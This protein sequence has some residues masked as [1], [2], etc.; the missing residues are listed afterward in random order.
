MSNELEKRLEAIESRISRIEQYL[1]HKPQSVASSSKPDENISE[2][3]KRSLEEEPSADFKLKEKKSGNWL[4]IVAVICFILAAGFM[5]KLSIESG[6]LTPARQLGIA[7][8]FGLGLIVAGFSLLKS[9]LKYASLLPASGVIVLYLTAFGAHR[10]YSI[11]SFEAAIAITAIVSA[12]CVWL[13][14]Q[15]KSDIYAIISAS[16]AFLS[17]IVLGLNSSAEFSLYYFLLCSVT[18]ASISIWVRSRV[19]TL[20]SA[21]LAIFMTAAV[22]INLNQDIL[23]AIIL[24]IHFAIFTVATYV[25]TTEHKEPLTY[26]ESWSFLP[27]LLVFYCAEYSFLGRIHPELAP[28]ISIV[29]AGLMVGLYL[30]AKKYFPD[31]LGSQTLVIAFTTIVFF[32]SVYIELLPK[33]LKAWLFCIIMLGF[34][35]YPKNTLQGVRNKGMIIP[36]IAIGIILLIE[37]LSI[38]FHL[39]NTS[40]NFSWVVVSIF[41]FASIWT[42]SFKKQDSLKSQQKYGYALLISAHLLATVGLYRLTTDIGSLAVSASW[43]CYAIGVMTLAFKNKDEVMAKSA[44]FVLA[45]AAGK[46]LLYDAASVATVIRIICLL[47]TGVVLYGCGFAMRKINNWNVVSTNV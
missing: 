26:S 28:W 22:G 31:T 19:I 8:T 34:A 15:I 18:F 25:Y 17:P 7:T 23:V 46:A 43:L 20:I 9:D 4:G 1:P 5:V 42:A 44:L 30:S 2:I 32:H 35:F 29:F 47:L 11:V 21:Y 12:L 10:Y 40:S 6:W 16:G 36:I 37:Y 27:V 14:T 41:A 39:L 24:A 45:F 13:Y 38:L 3:E 33:D